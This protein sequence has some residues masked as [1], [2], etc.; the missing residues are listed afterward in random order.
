MK[1]LSFY[2]QVGIVLPG[3]MF[4]LA[5]TLLFPSLKAQ[6]GADGVSVGGLGLFLLVA[7]AAG[8]LIAAG[9]NFLEKLIWFFAVGMPS[10]WI[11]KQRTTLLSGDE[12]RRIEAKLNKRLDSNLEVAKLDRA[13]WKPYFRHIYRAVLTAEP[14]GRVLTFNGN[15]GLNRGLATATLLA[16]TIVGFEHQADWMKWTAAL[17]LISFVYV[18]RMCRSG[19]LFAR[20]VYGVF[21]QLPDVC[22]APNANAK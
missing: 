15:Y 19:I 13:S 22:S 1:E 12:V 7:Y 11:V 21:A 9:G 8:Q 5:A 10:E 17:L 6:F 14:S 3:S 18:Y 2:E 16:G 20:E 4:L